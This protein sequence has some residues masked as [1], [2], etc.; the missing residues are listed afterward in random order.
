MK[1]DAEASLIEQ[2][3]AAKGNVLVVGHSNTV[4]SVVKRLGV[5][6]AVTVGDDE[7]DNLF[8]VSRGGAP[9]LLHLHYR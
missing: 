7:F 6:A 3:A 4:P 1:A 5:T 9:S 2:V 8:V